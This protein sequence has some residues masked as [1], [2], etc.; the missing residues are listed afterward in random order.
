MASHDNK[1]RIVLDKP[2]H[3]DGWLSY[4]KGAIN[5]D[6]IWSLVNP[7][8]PTKPTRTPYPKEPT[9]PAIDRNTGQID[10]GGMER[11][12]ALRLFR[13]EDLA[14][15][16]AEDKALRA[17][18]KLIFETTSARIITQVAHSEPDPWS[19]LVAL[20]QRLRPTRQTLSLQ[21]ERRFHQLA[22]GP[23][24]QNVDAW[25]TEWTEMYHEA[26]RMNIPE[27]S[28]DRAIRD[29]LLAVESVDPM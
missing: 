15:F 20:K 16:N 12:K 10:P 4:I 8:V 19:K 18:N 24:N 29:F 25:L 22:K 28:G 14:T 26:K 6:R 7:D 5:N 13:E 21:V 17:V 23:G 11:Y 1:Y 27:V 3:W 9:R 2:E